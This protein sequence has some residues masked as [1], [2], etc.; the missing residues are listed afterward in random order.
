MI[1]LSVLLVA[2]VGNVWANILPESFDVDVEALPG[3][4]REWASVLEMHAGVISVEEGEESDGNAGLFFWDFRQNSSS[5]NT[6]GSRPLV[7]WLNGGPG[8]SSMD[9]ALME[10]GP[11][12]V[13]DSGH[14]LEW[15]KGWFE[16]A[17]LVFIDQPV[18]TGFSPTSE[19]T[20]YDTTLVDS[21]A[22][23]MKFMHR[24]F[25]IFHL[26]S[27][28]SIIVAGESY[29][30]QY[31]PHLARALKDDSRFSSKVDTVLLGNAWLDPNLQSLAYVPY[32]LDT[33][34]VDPQSDKSSFS[35]LLS[36]QDQ[37]Q[38]IQN[39]E[40]VSK[41]PFEA[42]ECENILNK[43]LMSYKPGPKRCINV[44]DVSKDDSYP[45][46]GT[47]WPELLPA[48]T[49]YLSLAE[50]QEA[51][52]VSGNGM[53]KECNNDVHRSFTPRN[54]N[55]G[56]SL[57]SSLLNDGVHVNLFSG[58]NDLICN[59]LGTEAVIRKYAQPYLIAHNY[60]I[61]TSPSR[62]IDKF[63]MDAEWIHSGETAGA[64]WQRG[65]LTYV[66][67]ANASH[68]VAYDVSEASIGIL[69]LARR[70]NNGTV[71]KTGENSAVETQSSRNA[72]RVDAIILA[73]STAI[74]VCVL[75]YAVY[76]W[77]TR[78]QR[79]SALANS[80]PS[81]YTRYA[82][83]WMAGSGGSSRKKRVHWIDETDDLELASLPQNDKT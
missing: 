62:G 1:L 4:K 34:V 79:Y 36:L 35:Y 33:G 11:L 49:T 75:V 23:L 29:A 59:Y 20:P 28:E 25:D 9:G 52:H 31:V 6:C 50:V 68:M 2:L 58:M 37:C 72:Y 53:W 57:I 32:V 42:K 51:L 18:G 24:Y 3:F 82:Y 41:I 48:T 43:L 74:V 38:N 45:Q 19:S 22:H 44:Y 76:V 80:R 47:S 81:A 26:D 39:E 12:R 67:V 60:T 65:N 73:V 8:C 7:V 54:G 83:E 10:I 21:T 14:E 30:G 66:Q 78:P 5:G 69:D 17:D 55:Y 13:A 61:N 71:V 46:C 40:D 56:A 15:N 27:Y 16:K 77:R 63:E 64:L 70:A